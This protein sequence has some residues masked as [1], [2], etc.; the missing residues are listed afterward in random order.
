MAWTKN[1]FYLTMIPLSVAMAIISEVSVQVQAKSQPE[2]SSIQNTHAWKISQNFK[3]PNRGTP[4]NTSGGAT[5][6]SSC[7][8]PNQRVISLIPKEKFGLTFSERPKFFWDI[9]HI[10][11]SASQSAEFLLLDENE[12]LVYETTLTL[13]NKPGIFTFTL[14]DNAPGLK[15]SKQ[16]HWYLSVNCS[17]EETDGTTNFEGWI[18]RIK[19]D[20]SLQMKL[21]KLKPQD[22]STVYAEAGIWH[23]ALTNLAQSRCR[24]PNDSK[25]MLN[26]S[27]LL[28]S[29]GLSDVVSEPLNN[30]CKVGNSTNNP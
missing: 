14:P 29:V 3:T 12:D 17:S 18:K 4:T 30:I 26:W 27:K 19:P 28:T 11:K 1:S 9:S 24:Y 25:I 2:F 21:N 5:R 10:S 20:L 22:H 23:E 13:P 8:K 7:A 6:S 15:I 16:Y